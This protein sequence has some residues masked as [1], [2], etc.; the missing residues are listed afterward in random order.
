VQRCKGAYLPCARLETEHLLLDLLGCPDLS[1][2]LRHVLPS[3]LGSYALT[4]G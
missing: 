4:P 1:P 3:S 2:Y